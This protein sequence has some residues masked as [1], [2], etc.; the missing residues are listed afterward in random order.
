MGIG[1]ATIKS[2][3]E[4]VQPSKRIGYLYNVEPSGLFPREQA[5][6]SRAVGPMGGTCVSV[7]CLT[8]SPVAKNRGNRAGE[9][10]FF[11]H[12]AAREAATGALLR[13]PIQTPEEH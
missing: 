1:P 5:H 13:R 8:Q 4:L 11:S 10:P 2:K 9:A 7:G 3:S 12:P 6:S